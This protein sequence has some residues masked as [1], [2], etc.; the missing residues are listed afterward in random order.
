MQHDSTI[1]L[2]SSALPLVLGSLL[3]LGLVACG[4]DG[5][6]SGGDAGVDSGGACAVAATDCTDGPACTVPSCPAGVCE[7]VPQ[8]DRCPA[9]EA[10]CTMAA[11]DPEMGCVSVANTSNTGLL[12]DNGPLVNMPGAGPGGTD[13]SV[14]QQSLDMAL[15]GKNVGGTFRLADDFEVDGPESFHVMSI[16]LYAYQND[17]GTTPTIDHVNYRIWDGSPGDAESEVIYG[18]TEANRF[19]S[20]SFAG[21]YRLLEEDLDPVSTD[22]PVMRVVVS[23]D[24]VLGPGTYWLD[25]QR[26]GTLASGPWNPPV[27]IDGETETGNALQF[28]GG[29]WVVA[30]DH[31]GGEGTLDPQGMPFLLRGP[32]V[33]PEPE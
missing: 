24:V 2:S 23:A 10:G 6:S 15:R 21:I 1:R 4:S 33:T 28:S 29:E 8:H 27:T 25:W 7:Y 13:L 3:S 19:V 14:V 26:G 9:D 11:C 18:D 32:C 22:R 16:V 30:D 31:V 12:W 17:S 20:A 5:S